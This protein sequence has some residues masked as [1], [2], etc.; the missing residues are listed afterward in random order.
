MLIVPNHPRGTDEWGNGKIL[1][2]RFFYDG[3]RNFGPY[4]KTLGLVFHGTALVFGLLILSSGK[5]VIFQQL[6]IDQ[7]RLRLCGYHFDWLPPGTPR[8][9]HRKVCP[10]PGLLHNRKCPEAGPISDN[11]PGAWLCI[12]WLSNMKIVNTVISA[13]TLSCLSAVE[14]LVKSRRLRMLYKT[15]YLLFDL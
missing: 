11:V 4:F 13:Y 2:P 6:Q 14:G 15:V 5:C 10:V 9:L 8:L 7:A 3:P 1:S 12:N